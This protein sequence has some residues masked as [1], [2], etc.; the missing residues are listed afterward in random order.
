MFALSPVGGL[1]AGLVTCHRSPT[2]FLVYTVYKWQSNEY[3]TPA[4]MLKSNLFYSKVIARNVNI[5]ITLGDETMNSSLAER[6]RSLMFPQ[7]QPLLHFLVRMKLTST[8]V[9]LQV[10]KNVE[11]TRGKI[12][13]VP[14][15][16]KCFPGKSLKFIPHHIGSMG[17]GVI[18]QMD[19]S[20]R[21]N[22]RM[23][24]LYGASQHPH[25]PRNEPHLSVL[26]CL[27]P[28]PMLD[29]HT[30]HYAHLLSNKGR[31]RWTVHFHNACLLP[32]RWQF[33]Y[34]TTV[35][36]AFARNEFYGWCSDFTAPHN[37]LWIPLKTMLI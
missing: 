6:G 37:S 14:R 11:V 27:P 25:P 31:T 7:P 24:W 30:L 13:T 32:Y 5:F 2:T 23:F 21:Q 1:C 16:L 12:W 20:V 36:P 3:R 8:N 17:T 33:R 26:L 18:M 10:A 35:L 9:F 4:T 29:E 34:I 19:D 15:M 28:F 22:S